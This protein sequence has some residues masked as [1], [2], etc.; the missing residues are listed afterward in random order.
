MG[1]YNRL[2]VMLR[3]NLLTITKLYIHQNPGE[4]ENY[5]ISYVFAFINCGAD[6]HSP[7]LC[8]CTELWR[9][10]QSYNPQYNLQ[11]S[12]M[13]RF[14]NRIYAK[15]TVIY[16]LHTHDINMLWCID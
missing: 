4:K 3:G 11:K 14:G 9:W 2:D 5:E 13:Q 8:R 15:R 1:G 16:E 6:K 7:T 10:K 12:I